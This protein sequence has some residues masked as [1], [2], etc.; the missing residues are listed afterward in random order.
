MPI[1]FILASL[2]LSL[3]PGPDIFFVMTQSIARGSR[4]A[5]SVTLGLCSGLFFHTAAVALGLAALMAASPLCMTLVKIFGGL[6]LFWIGLCALRASKSGDKSASPNIKP[7]AQE[8]KGFFALYKQ[9]LIMNLLNPKVILFFL[10]FLPAFVP[11][12]ISVP[13]GVYIIFLGFCFALSA[14]T[15]FGAVSFF[16][17]Y[18]NDVLHIGRYAQSKAFAWISALIYWLIAAWILFA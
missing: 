6:Y 17:G 3:M 14:L 4:A 5:L 9:G 10:S 2:L 15:V 1:K 7:S 11:A 13:Y 18:L 8:Q 12:D 16:G